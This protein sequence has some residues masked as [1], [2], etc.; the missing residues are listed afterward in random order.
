MNEIFKRLLESSDD[1]KTFALR[2]RESGVRTVRGAASNFGIVQSLFVANSDSERD[3]THYFLL[4]DFSGIQS[5]LVYTTRALP[6]GVLSENDLPKVRIF[7]LAAGAG[8]RRLK[9]I[10][11]GQ[12]KLELSE[13]EVASESDL[14]NAL[15]RFAEK[16]DEQSDFLTGGIMFVGGESWPALIR[17]WG[18]VSRWLG[19]PREWEPKHPCRAPSI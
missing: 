17:W 14:A 5:G 8:K 2:L 18:S 16:V 10:L 19:G 13:E 6:E 11:E 9:A 1:L 15:E 4:P 12:V 7:H 3:E